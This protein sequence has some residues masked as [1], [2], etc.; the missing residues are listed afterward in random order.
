MSWRKRLKLNKP[1]ASSIVVL[2]LSVILQQNSEAFSYVVWGDGS[3]YYLGNGTTGQ[4]D[5]QSTNASLVINAAIGNMT[6]G[7]IYLRYGVPVANLIAHPNII[8]TGE[9]GFQNAG[10]VVSCVN[11]TAIAHGLAGTPTSITLSLRGP[12]QYNATII[13]CAPT[14]LSVNA[15]HF[16]IE[17]TAWETVGWTLVPI[18]AVEAQT[19]YWDAVYK[20]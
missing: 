12:T 20:P 6:Y 7:T 16:L 9:Y 19:V 3:N 5:Y 1:K 11:G 14:V 18:T 2:V 10:S 17:L 15:T 8:I 4:V 13:L